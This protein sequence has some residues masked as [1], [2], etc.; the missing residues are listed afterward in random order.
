MGP[1][2]LLFVR[3]PRSIALVLG[4]LG[5]AGEPETP[6]TPA[7]MPSGADWELV[8]ASAFHQGGAWRL[9]A[10]VGSDEPIHEC[11]ES[12]RFD[13]TRLSR[14]E[15][16]QL[17]GA[18]SRG[19]AVFVAIPEQEA[20]PVRMMTS[21][22]PAE[23][24]VTSC[25]LSLGFD[26]RFVPGEYEL[27]AFWVDRGSLGARRIVLLPPDPSPARHPQPGDTAYSVRIRDLERRVQ[28]LKERV[29]RVRRRL[30]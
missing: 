22:L 11:G 4:L 28:E 2:K 15:S 19:S 24:G 12:F 5:C 13:V 9:V 14:Y 16:S 29:R 8:Q 20:E 6:I 3:T 1:A 27:H 23:R 25:E 21:C 7:R 18:S 30:W 10:R 17:E 26:G